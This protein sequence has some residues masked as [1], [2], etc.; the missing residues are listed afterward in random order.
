MAAP[1]GGPARPGGS[2][3]GAGEGPVYVY[4]PYPPYPEADEVDLLESVRA[5]YARRWPIVGFVGLCCAVAAVVALLLP[6]VY[7]ATAVIAPVDEESRGGL[8]GL[9]GQFGG[10]A[11]L[12]GVS[13]GAP[14]NTRQ[15]IAI[16]TS[17]AFTAKLVEE[18]DLMPVLFAELWDP[19][20][21][22][23]TVPDDEMPDMWDAYRAFQGIREVDEDPK[24]GLVTVSI[25]WGDPEVA[26]TWVRL[27]IDT[28]NRYLQAEAVR[29][30]EKSIAYLMDQVDKT[31]NVE[32]R[33][34]LFNLVESQTKK[35]ML[36]RV[37]EDFAFK[38]I[39]P[40]VAPDRRARPRRTLIVVMTFLASG[41]LAVMGALV[42]EYVARGRRRP[43]GEPG[44]GTP[45]TGPA[46]PPET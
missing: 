10:L 8:S 40:P 45:G 15:Q 26:A 6:P 30:A 1:E 18:N 14:D 35:A 9:V 38:V 46:N 24:T 7:R 16:L 36:A 11:P 21:K 34:T 22:R 27:H 2:G 31:S 42:A 23:W 17:R 25:E 3:S 13:L 19:A 43:G 4:P 28:L 33:Q 5:V 32:M 12:A 39:D 37:R 29:E 20:A 41:L 44:G